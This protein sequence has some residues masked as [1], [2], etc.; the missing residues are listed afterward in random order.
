MSKEFGIHAD[1]FCHPNLVSIQQMKR[2]SIVSIVIV[3]ADIALMQLLLLFF[4]FCHDM[5][6]Q[7][8]LC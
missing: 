8:T 3:I 2:P 7:T 5:V 1:T 4:F 6:Y